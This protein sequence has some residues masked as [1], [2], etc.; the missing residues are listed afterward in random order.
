[1]SSKNK[2]E[3]YAVASTKAFIEYKGKILILRESP[4]YKSGSNHGKYVMP[5]GKVNEDECFS[6]ALKRE[7]KEECGL[8][9]K[10]GK[11]FHVGEWKISIPNKPKHIVGIYFFCFSTSDSIK[12]N[13]EFD[14]YKW[15]NP[16]E[17]KKYDINFA[18]KRAFKDYLKFK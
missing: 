8:N 10:I 11:P 15:I 9:I 5:G 14:S 6:N 1:M 18:A 13:E 3:T 17:Y 7:V 16:Q 2:K 12:L 4:K